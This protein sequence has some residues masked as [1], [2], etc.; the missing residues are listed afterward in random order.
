MHVVACA[1]GWGNN[2]HNENNGWNTNFYNTLWNILRVSR[3]YVIR[4]CRAHIGRL[5]SDET[6]RKCWI[7]MTSD[8][9]QSEY[10]I[11]NGFFPLSIRIDCIRVR[12]VPAPARAT[13][14]SIVKQMTKG[15]MRQID[16]EIVSEMYWYIYS[17][18]CQTKTERT[19]LKRKIQ[20]AFFSAKEFVLLAP[21]INNLPRVFFSSSRFTSFS[22]EQNKKGEK[23]NHSPI[24]SYFLRQLSLLEAK[25]EQKKNVPTGFRRKENQTQQIEMIYAFTGKLKAISCW[26][27]L[28]PFCRY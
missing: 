2:S 22:T 25:R 13:Y 16:I 24:F 27:R 6:S 4:I 8:G 9:S 3:F 23:T 14:R 20:A 28:L 11:E 19:E 7:K 17:K 26:M 12:S 10:G 1:N 15:L 21:N 5:A 18:H